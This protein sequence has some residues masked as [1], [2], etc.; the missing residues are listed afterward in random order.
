MQQLTIDLPDEL[1]APNSSPGSPLGGTASDLVGSDHTGPMFCCW[2]SVTEQLRL[3]QP[4]W[5]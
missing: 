1:S 4:V 2:T 5:P 3:A